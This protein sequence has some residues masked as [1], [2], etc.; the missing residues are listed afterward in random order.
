MVPSSVINAGTLLNRA[1]SGS[2]RSGRGLRGRGSSEGKRVDRSHCWIAGEIRP[3]Q[4]KKVS[5]PLNDHGRDQAS[6][7]DLNPG[8]RVGNDKLLPDL[9]RRGGNRSRVEGDNG[10]PIST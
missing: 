5:N 4:G 6:V 7:V 1:R 2:A 10:S 8:N 3:V 9:V